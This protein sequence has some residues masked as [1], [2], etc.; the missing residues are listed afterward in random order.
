MSLIVPHWIPS[1]LWWALP[2]LAAALGAA[3]RRVLP[4]TAA[5]RGAPVCLLAGLAGMLIWRGALVAG[6]ASRGRIWSTGLP[7]LALA[8]LAAGGAGPARHRDL[9]KRR[10]AAGHRSVPAAA[11]RHPPLHQSGQKQPAFPHPVGLFSC[12]VSR[13]KRAPG[14]PVC[15]RFGG[16]VRQSLRSPFPRLQMRPG[17]VA[18]VGTLRPQARFAGPAPG[19]EIVRRWRQF[20]NFRQQRPA[21][22]SPRPAFCAGGSPGAGGQSSYLVPWRSAPP[23]RSSDPPGREPPFVPPFTLPPGRL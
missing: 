17:P 6:L 21:V 11:G 23:C 15:S 7:L 3:L 16:A 19:P 10:P 4:R 14:R 8:V 13:A 1:N 12:M 20:Y 18:L 5:A 9:H 2:L 22:F